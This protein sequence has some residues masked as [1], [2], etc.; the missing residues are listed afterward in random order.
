MSNR[1]VAVLLSAYNGEKFIREQIN[2]L[3][4]QEGVDVTI[5]VRDDGSSD[6]TTQILQEYA[7]KGQIQL[8][9]GKNVGFVLSF[10]ELV[11]NAP[12]SDYYAFC[13]Q[14]DVWL[15][16][17]LKNAVDALEQED[18][19]IP[20]LYYTSLTV[21]NEKLEQ[22]VDKSCGYIDETDPN[23]F[24]NAL[25]NTGANGCT[26]VFNNATREAF[27]RVPKH[28]IIGHDYSVNTIASGLGKVIF[29]RDSQILYRQHANNAFGYFSGGIKILW[30]SLKAFFCNEM[31]RL[32]F[33]EAMT[34]NYVF[35][36]ELSPDKK[37]FIDLMTQY[38][39]GKKFKRLLKKYIKANISNKTT[40]KYACLLLNLG[41]L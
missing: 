31:K 13:D 28:C 10:R 33:R 23:V 4:A 24:Q 17:K 3:L 15:P 16:H 9:V 12:K 26:E 27:L 20:L 36:D 19:S 7:D 21:V 35:Y 1:K 30:R 25:L 41:G 5:C 34:F 8:E 29:S 37:E 39:R 14:D 22:I 32:R 18:N 2:S 11:A 38:K 40:R 6:S